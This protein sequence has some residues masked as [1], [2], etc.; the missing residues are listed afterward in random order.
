MRN[1]GGLFAVLALLVLAAAGGGYW[2]LTKRNVADLIDGSTTATTADRAAQAVV[3]ATHQ[4][5]E[6]QRADVAVRVSEGT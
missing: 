4:L 5:D 2:F 3:I 1:K 6:L